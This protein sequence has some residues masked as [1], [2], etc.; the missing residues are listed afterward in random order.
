MMV[1]DARHLALGM[2]LAVGTLFLAACSQSDEPQQSAASP[3]ATSQ[4]A[5][6]PAS[7]QAAAPTSIPMGG[8]QSV[9]RFFVTSKGLGKGGDLG[10]LAGA[11]AHCQALAKAQGAGDHTWRA[12]LST[13]A[14]ATGP[15]VNARD[16]IGNGPWYNAEG[17]LIAQ[18]LAELHGKASKLDKETAVT[19]SVE[20]V[21]AE[22]HEV[23][24]GSRPDGTAFEAGTDRTCGNWTSSTTGSA[25]VGYLDLKGEGENPD[26]WNSARQ[27]NSCSAETFQKRR[28]AGLFYCFAIN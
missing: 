10:G 1:F 3:P 4:A 23:L 8:A 13:Q 20:P 16:R 11:D 9:T 28:G 17:D 27:T 6:P 26:S 15:A 14:S 21:D 5:A 12:Y 25:Q 19:E 18:N 22:L 7:A 24:T 2:T